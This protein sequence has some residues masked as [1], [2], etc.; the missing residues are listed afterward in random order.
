MYVDFI[1]KNENRGAESRSLKCHNAHLSSVKQR[2][3]F[4]FITIILEFLQVQTTA[5]K[6]DIGPSADSSGGKPFS[7]GNA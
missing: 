4:I 7:L 5:A 3:I 1:N 2:K 6:V